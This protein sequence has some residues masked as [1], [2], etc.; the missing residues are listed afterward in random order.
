MMAQQHIDDWMAE[1]FVEERP[2]GIVAVDLEGTL[3]Q[4]ETWKGIARWLKQN[5]YALDYNLFFLKHLPQAMLMKQGLSDRT[6]FNALWM[7]ELLYLFKGFSQ[8]EFEEMVEWVVREETWAN[9]RQNLIDELRA[10]QAEGC[11]IVIVS[12]TY[13]A[14]AEAVGRRLGAS[15]AFGTLVEI[16]DDHLTGFLSTPINV[17]EQKALQ[18]KRY[19]DDD[20][21]LVAAYGDTV[22][23]IPMLTLSQYPVAV[24]PDEGLRAEALKNNWRIME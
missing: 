10:H 8:A 1:A 5:G 6:A 13:Q 23:D 12:G 15:T 11:Q 22:A 16:E 7:T 9:R 24:A 4:G 21:P 18:L 14:I 3:T 17:G 19:L 20:I 2:S